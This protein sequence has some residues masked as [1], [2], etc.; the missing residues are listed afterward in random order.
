MAKSPP[1]LTLPAGSSLVWGLMLGGG[2]RR[3]VLSSVLCQH[4]HLVSYPPTRV[5]DAVQGV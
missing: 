2:A 4:G 5:K 1:L 3:G